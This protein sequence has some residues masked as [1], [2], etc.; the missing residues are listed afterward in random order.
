MVGV[1]VAPLTYP[2][3]PIYKKTREKMKAIYSAPHRSICTNPNPPK[4]CTT[5]PR[6]PSVSCITCGDTCDALAF[7]KRREERDVSYDYSGIW[8]RERERERRKEKEIDNNYLR[9]HP[10]LHSNLSCLPV[11][12]LSWSYFVSVCHM[13]CS[14]GHTRTVL[15]RPP[16]L[17]AALDQLQSLPFESHSCLH[18]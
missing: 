11:V 13:E 4:L 5:I 17:R 6:C 2:S 9:D 8:E 10:S 16:T 12:R 3:Q 1:G 14:L 15:C 7:L 18:K